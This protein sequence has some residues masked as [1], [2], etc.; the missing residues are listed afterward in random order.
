MQGLATT[1]IYDKREYL[2]D[3]QMANDVERKV[4]AAVSTVYLAAALVNEKI[5]DA[6]KREHVATLGFSEAKPGRAPGKARFRVPSSIQL[7]A[8][9]APGQACPYDTSLRPCSCRGKLGKR[10]VCDDSESVRLLKVVFYPR[11]L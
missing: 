3:E 9:E 1:E 10:D 2:I 6:R 5:G 7:H 11:F 8:L 4:T